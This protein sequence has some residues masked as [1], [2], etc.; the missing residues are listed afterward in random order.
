[1]SLY[2]DKVLKARKKL[3]NL[4][5]SQ[6]KEL[7]NLYKELA[8]QLSNE[9][10]NCRTSSQ[11]SYLKKLSELVEVNINQL[12]NKLNTMIK[13]NIESSSQIAGTIQN[14]YYQSIT[15][16]AALLTMFNTMAINNSR[17]T[18]SKLIQG[19]YY[20]DGKTLDNRLWSITEKN[21]NDINNL[22][23]VNV[24]R[25]ANARE[26]AKQL[27]KYVNPTKV[28]ESHALEDGMNPKIAY[29]AQRL[30]RTSITHSFAETTIANA[31][32]NPFN[33][34]IKW[35][36]SASHDIR[37][38]GKKDICDDYAGRVFKPDSVPLQHP[39]CLCYFTE[40]NTDIDEAIKELKE[41]SNGS[42]NK[43]LDKWY[44]SFE[45]EN[46]DTKISN[47]NEEKKW[48]NTK[49]SVTNF[50]DKKEI[51]S[52]LKEKYNIK[53]SDS[54]K[55]PIDK[56]ILQDS[57]NWLDKFHNYFDGFKE[58]DPVIL[59]AIKIKAG[60][61]PVGYYTY[62][63]NE[64]EAVELVLNGLYFKDKKSNIEY[65]ER[66]IKTNWTVANAKSYKTFVHEYGH[67]IANSLKWLDNSYGIV[68]E[69]WCKDFIND[70]IKDY[71]IKYSSDIS[72]RHISKLVSEYGG[73]KP[74][75]AF[76]E[77]FAEYFG[78]DNPREFATVFGEKVEEKIK[79]YIKKERGYINGD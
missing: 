31:K 14:I 16:N 25:G 45:K 12:N 54:T 53:F 71:N 52:Y 68:K 65:I 58:I 47:I 46:K 13:E 64:A 2:E 79:N 32:T 22:I 28:L 34:G 48:S 67:H 37:M 26:L 76:A 72:F 61:N 73:S 66:C 19:N 49:S 69:N 62:Y 35:N 50:K 8:D 11:S 21:K 6:E 4:N 78:G 33:K 55:Y 60:I 24:L 42:S 18:V 3:L 63:K 10:L 39:N 15:D 1:M 5:K 27:N 51:K 77:A 56:D 41:W 36:L 17:K 29:Q 57:I 30:A 75:E 38:H 9:I 59:P 7:L 20:K 43:K 74:E 70:V 23:K 40:E 44:E